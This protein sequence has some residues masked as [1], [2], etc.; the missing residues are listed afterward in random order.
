MVSKKLPHS[1]FLRQDV[2][3]V[4]RE[5]L[6][7]RLFT[8]VGGQTVTG[9][10]IVETEAYGGIHDRASH[11]CGGRRTRRT[12]VMY[13][14][15]GVAYVY[16]C[17]GMHCLFNII[18]NVEGVPDAV[19]VR[20]IAPICGVEVMLRRRQRRRL[21]YTLTAGPGVLTRAL[22]IGLKHNGL[23]VAGD[24]IWIEQ[25]RCCPA[26]CI[27]AGPRVGVAYAGADARRP[28][29]LHIRGNPWVS[30]VK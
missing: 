4:S 30:C 26:A 19:L 18:T 1:F 15:G 24:E 9:G 16:L 21:D 25:D 11:A 5:L 28:W 13:A 23:S 6:G 2:V 7:A 3:Q 8:R 22:G 17:Y 20:A 27:E 14:Q 12:E 29:R 10:I